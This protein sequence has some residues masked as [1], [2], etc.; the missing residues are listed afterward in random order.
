MEL[1][2]YQLPTNVSTHINICFFKCN[3]VGSLIKHVKFNYSCIQVK[4]KLLKVE[5]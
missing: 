1:F 5:L 4:F 2:L 3:Y